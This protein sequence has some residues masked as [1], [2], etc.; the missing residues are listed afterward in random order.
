MDSQKI[1]FFMF[2]IIT[3]SLTG[4]YFLDRYQVKDKINQYKSD[5]T[6]IETQLFANDIIMEKINNARI[7]SESVMDTIKSYNLSGTQLMDEISRIRSLANQSNILVSKVEID[8]KNTFPE[9]FYDNSKVSIGL[10]RQ[11]LSLKLKGNFLEVGE[12]LETLEKKGSPLRIQSCM[13]LLDSLDPK[14]IIAQLRFS[15]YTGVKL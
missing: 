3:I 4:L 11:T 5:I 13:L 10:E 9:K 1:K 14:G 6:S 7:A 2:W 8:P 15:T 12:L